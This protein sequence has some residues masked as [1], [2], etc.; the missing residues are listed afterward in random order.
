M[1]RVALIVLLTFIVG[2]GG[3]TKPS[4]TTSSIVVTAS[5]DL[6]FIGTVET[7]AATATLSNGTTQAVTTGAWGSDQPGIISVEPTTGRGTVVGAGQTTVWVDYQG[8]RGTKAIRGLPNYQGSWSG[9]YVVISC[10]QTGQIAAAN[11]C[12]DTFSV[13][14][15]LPV[16][17]V[18][19]QTRDAVTSQI[20]LGTIAG[21]GNGPVQN[22]G[23]LLLAGTARS[24]DLSIDTVWTLLSLQVGRITGA[25][26]FIVRFAGVGGEVRVSVEIRDLNKQST[27]AVQRAPG[28]QTAPKTL[29][30]IREA[31]MGRR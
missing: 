8:V 30:D 22:N 13:N 10:T 5:S 26:S 31:L 21:S 25:G 7:F 15:V 16:N 20:F 29:G 4:V 1:H 6:L 17:L 19:T 12:N 3:S 23:E 27:V 11:L 24:G 18:T 28:I 14:R 2:C 9:T